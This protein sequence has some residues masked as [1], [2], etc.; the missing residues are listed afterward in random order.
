MTKTGVDEDKKQVLKTKTGRLLCVGDGVQG[1][2]V[3]RH[4]LPSSVFWCSSEEFP[5]WGNEM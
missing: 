2:V 3:V 4:V 5:N 1:E